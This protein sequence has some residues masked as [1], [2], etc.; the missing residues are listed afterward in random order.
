MWRFFLRLGSVI[1]HLRLV[2]ELIK[3]LNLCFPAPFNLLPE[4]ILQPGI[5]VLSLSES[6]RFAAQPLP[7][8]LERQRR[9]VHVLIRYLWPASIFVPFSQL[10]APLSPCQC[11]KRDEP[12]ASWQR[13]R[14]RSGDAA[15]KGEEEARRRAVA[16]DEMEKGCGGR[17]GSYAKHLFSGVE[18]WSVVPT[19]F[20]DIIIIYKI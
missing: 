4:L 14:N 2:L 20:G 16:V 9:F 12:A 3:V 6:G 8:F 19:P 1:T 13:N 7:H 11:G 5:V 17:R 10:P 15:A 18:D